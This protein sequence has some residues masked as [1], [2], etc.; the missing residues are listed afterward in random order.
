VSR[1]V[2]AAIFAGMALICAALAASTA[3]D[4]RSGVEAQLGEL[5]SVL[6][7]RSEVPAGR[8]LR[9]RDADELLE[10]R[11][12]P[13]RFAPADGL[14]D[15]V[16][17]LGLEPHAPIPAGAYV[18]SA[19]LRLPPEAAPRTRRAA[20]RGREAVEITV[21]GAEALA[22]GGAAP[23]RGEVDVVATG[24]QGGSAAGS[25]DVI[26]TGVRLLGLREASLAEAAGGLGPE[27]PGAWV[28]TLGTTRAQA[29]RLIHAH[30]YAR[31]VRLIEAAGEG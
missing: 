4:Y 18:T 2:R 28:A 25:T 31:E 17:A 24:E 7:A 26:A 5:R 1:R 14:A 30:N 21:V 8:A 6:V 13:A 20:G 19:Q 3:S 11:R 16:E 15:P 27:G 12:V 29:L 22:P 9:P 23:A 10:V